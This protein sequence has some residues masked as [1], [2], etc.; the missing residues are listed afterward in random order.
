MGESVIN[1]RN[2][3]KKKRPN[4]NVKVAMPKPNTSYK[5]L[6]KKQMQRI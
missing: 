6:V 2:H 1:I 3:A 5:F 4:L